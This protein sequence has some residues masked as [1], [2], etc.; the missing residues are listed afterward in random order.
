ML[1]LFK[2]KCNNC[3]SENIKYKIVIINNVPDMRLVFM[4]CDN[5]E[6]IHCNDIIVYI[7]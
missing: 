4:N 3:W 1:N 2:L 6:H 7:K 5:E